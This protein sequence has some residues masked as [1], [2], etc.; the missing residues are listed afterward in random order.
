VDGGKAGSEG[1]VR[2]NDIQIEQGRGKRRTAKKKEKTNICGALPDQESLKVTLR[3]K[4]RSRRGKGE[5]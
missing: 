5:A 3:I 4:G 2:R 1:S